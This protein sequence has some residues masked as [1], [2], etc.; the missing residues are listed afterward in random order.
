MIQ[1]IIITGWLILFSQ[2]ISAQNV[3]NVLAEIEQNNTTLAAYKN[4]N[5]AE[6]LSHKTDIFLENPEIGFNY[7][8]GNPAAIGKR[9]DFSISQSF[10][11]PTSYR[12][13]KRIANEK[14]LLSDLDFELQRKTILYRAK[15]IC[16]QLIYLNALHEVLAVRAGHAKKIAT[17]FNKK[18][19]KGEINIIENNKAKFNLLNTQKELEANQTE[20]AALLAELVGL[21]GGKPVSFTQ[22]VFPRV[23]FP[24]NF[25][26]WFSQSEQKNIFLQQAAKEIEIS[27]KQIKL[28]RAMSL[29]KFSGGYMSESV[30][31]ESFKGVSAGMTIPLW[32]NKNKIKLATAQKQ[33]ALQ[34][35]NDKKIEIYNHLKGKYEKA[36]SLQKILADY[37]ETLQVVNSTELLKKALDAGE[38]SLIEY[39]LELTLYYETT[40][41]FLEIEN[42]LNQLAAELYFFD[43]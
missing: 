42:E 9:H 8:W 1:K 15:T 14:N 5:E 18:F 40:D 16:N 21:N 12:I 32:E 34:I 43:L 31:G 29:P 39:M 38:L 10:D 26:T 3:K 4:L 35:A 20:R 7:L 17:A 37:K 33:V 24:G 23:Q 41:K 6:K 2:I 19:E 11:F 27:E 22:S 28:S 36:K 25:D 13:K 30:V